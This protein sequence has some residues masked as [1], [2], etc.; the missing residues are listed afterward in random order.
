MHSTGTYRLFQFGIFATKTTDSRLILRFVFETE[1]L[2][3]Y[4]Y[5]HNFFTQTSVDFKNLHYVNPSKFQK[6][7]STVFGT[8]SLTLCL[9]YSLCDLIFLLARKMLN[10]SRYRI[11]QKGKNWLNSSNLPCLQTNHMHTILD[12]LF[13]VTAD[14][15]YNGCFKMF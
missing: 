7:K 9:K 4:G 10:W 13:S 8:Y 14:F 11:W 5:I 3:F 15:R 1:S 2:L 12:A 6:L